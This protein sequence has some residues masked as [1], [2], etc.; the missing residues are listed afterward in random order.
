MGIGMDFEDVL[1]DLGFDSPK[2]AANELSV[3]ASKCR[4]AALDVFTIRDGVIKSRYREETPQKDIEDDF[5]AMLKACFNYVSEIP[6][7]KSVL[8]PAVF[9]ERKEY[10]DLLKKDIDKDRSVSVS[11][12]F[13]MLQK[14]ERVVSGV[15]D[16]LEGPVRAHRI[17]D[18]WNEPDHL[19]N[20]KRETAMLATGYII[21][22][23]LDRFKRDRYNGRSGRDHLYSIGKTPAKGHK[24][25]QAPT[26]RLIYGL[27]DMFVEPKELLVGL[28]EQQV[29]E[30]RENYGNKLRK[31]RDVRKMFSN[32]L[33]KKMK[34]RRVLMDSDKVLETM[35]GEIKPLTPLDIASGHPRQL[36][37]RN[38]IAE[39]EEL[40]ERTNE[41]L[42]AYIIELG[43]LHCSQ[44]GIYDILFDAVY[45]HPPEVFWV[46][47]SQLTSSGYQPIPGFENL[48]PE[49]V[50][51]PA[52]DFKF[53]K[54]MPKIARYD[55][56][57]PPS[58]MIA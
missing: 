20:Q 36:E 41:V 39:D 6:I 49:K 33:R 35:L 47:N 25:F 17:M 43:G 51:D 48:P 18:G 3:E 45:G 12:W 24:P 31:L 50:V 37:Y 30:Y 46:L 16:Y 28:N 21:T 22:V 7:T 26:A 29:E 1:M 54:L 15:E 40:L 53:Y 10:R 38:M 42:E 55:V 11:P 56:T 32:K 14:M 44:I 2:E 34:V 52:N 5:G 27:H 57:E 13:S 23:E 19:E 4:N 9:E 8:P 58:G